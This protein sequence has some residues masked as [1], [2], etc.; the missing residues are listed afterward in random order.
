MQHDCDTTPD[1]YVGLYLPGEPFEQAYCAFGYPDGTLNCHMFNGCT[2]SPMGHIRRG[3]EKG[4]FAVFTG[5]R[6]SQRAFSVKVSQNNENSRRVSI[7]AST[8]QHNPIAVANLRD[9]D[10]KK[11]PKAGQLVY[12]VECLPRCEVVIAVL[13]LVGVDRMS[14]DAHE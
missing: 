5:D 4:S 1:E 13:I 3:Q 11:W 12:E 10:E 8:D 2:K 9:G 14:T 7:F 6:Q